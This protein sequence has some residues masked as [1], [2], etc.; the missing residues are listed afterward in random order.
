MDPVGRDIRLYFTGFSN[1]YARKSRMYDYPVISSGFLMHANGPDDVPF[2]YFVIFAN[3]YSNFEIYDAEINLVK[4][5]TA[6][7][8]SY[9]Y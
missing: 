4:N 7:L 2:L 1:R 9:N 6:L 3:D 8:E 5:K